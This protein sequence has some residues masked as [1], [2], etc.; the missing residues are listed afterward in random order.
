VQVSYNEEFLL[1]ALQR[2]LQLNEFR[3]GVHSSEDERGV[4]KDAL[5][6]ARLW[7]AIVA[8]SFDPHAAVAVVLDTEGERRFGVAIATARD[9]PLGVVESVVTD[10]FQ[11]P[12]EWLD[13]VPPALNALDIYADD[14]EGLSLDGIGY[15]VLVARR[16]VEAEFSFFNPVTTGLKNL[17]SAIHT[18]LSSAADES[19]SE[20]L[21]EFAATAA[22]S[23]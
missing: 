5:R 6:V 22:R 13:P 10:S 3:A 2:E 1:H 9:A 8:P 4:K 14:D 17:E 11:L 7:V 12:A 18:A 19:R 15:R 16:M 23:S 21:R 20:R